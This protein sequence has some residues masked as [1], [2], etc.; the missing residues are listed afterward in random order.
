MDSDAETFRPPATGR[1]ELTVYIDSEQQPP[2]AHE[3]VR[4]PL[5]PMTMQPSQTR[6]PEPTASGN[7]RPLVVGLVALA[8]A[9]GGFAVWYQWRQTRRCLAFYGPDAAR[10]VQS[11]PRV[12]LWELARGPLGQL[13]RG[14]VRDVST[15]A[16][17]VHLR[18]GLVEDANFRWVPSGADRLPASAWDVALAFYASPDAKDAA[19]ILAIDLDE[20]GGAVTLVGRP[21]RVGLGRMASGLRRW[22]AATDVASPPPAAA[23]R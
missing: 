2:V 11:A 10:S 17:L 21:G 13:V 20:D 9:V 23:G 6:R 15:A 8:V 16:G 7:G 14:R 22:I 19:V 3:A 18:H 4:V 1:R 5:Q 12:E